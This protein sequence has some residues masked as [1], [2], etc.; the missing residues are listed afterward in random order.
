MP[1]DLTDI[2]YME[3]ITIDKVIEL[4]EDFSDGHEITIWA[5]DANHHFIKAS[6]TRDDFYKRV[7][8]F[9]VISAI[10]IK[11]LNYMLNDIN[12]H[13]SEIITGLVLFT[14]V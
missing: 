1:T 5:D 13:I 2:K 4:Y 12:G 9:S 7:E 10:S 14:S 8:S 3:K 6:D 11:K